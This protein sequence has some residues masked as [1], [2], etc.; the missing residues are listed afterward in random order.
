[1]ELYAK[2]VNLYL[3]LIA[4]WRLQRVTKLLLKL[5]VQYWTASARTLLFLTG[6]TSCLVTYIYIYQL[7]WCLRLHWCAEE[8]KKFFK[9][10][11][12]CAIDGYPSTLELQ[13]G[14]VHQP[15][16]QTT[17]EEAAFLI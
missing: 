3:W 4:Q 2:L 16:S 6:C 8:V 15:N 11:S 17:V 14:E 9:E 5:K 1:M 13:Y 7:Y 10:S 12:S